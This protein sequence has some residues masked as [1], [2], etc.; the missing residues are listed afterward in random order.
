MD[1]L[2]SAFSS[3]G[4]GDIGKILGI[5]STGYNLYN[6]FQNQQYQNNLRSYAQNPQ[7]LNAYA[8]K[9]TQPLTAGLT[10]GVAN[11]TQAY[12]ANR[13]LSESPQISEAVESQAIAPYLQQ[14][15]NQGYQDALQALG[16]GGGAIPPGE[17]K[18][19]AQNGL[20][21]AFANAPGSLPQPGGA[22]GYAL[23]FGNQNQ[24]LPSQYQPIASE[25]PPI[26]ISSWYNG[27]TSYDPSI[28]QPS[29]GSA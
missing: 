12:L 3:G 21:S 5:G 15:Q 7:K 10:Q 6:Q 25:P 19:S 27:Q 23:T 29:Y 16:L 9:F 22:A 1:A 2:T 20:A 4:L 11:Q 24:Q 13:G 8:Q 18:Q 14:Q 28:F 17:Q 26:D